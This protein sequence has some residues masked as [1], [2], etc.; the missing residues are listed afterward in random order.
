MRTESKK[1]ARLAHPIFVTQV[2]TYGLQNKIPTEGELAET[3]DYLLDCAAEEGWLDGYSVS[4]GRF[5]V[6]VIEDGE[7]EVSLELA[8][9]YL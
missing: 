3:V 8:N 7:F 2:W 6:D 5:R 4:T 1:A 9:N